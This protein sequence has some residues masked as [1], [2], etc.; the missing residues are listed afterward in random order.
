MSR[1]MDKLVKLQ[2]EKASVPPVA[3]APQVDQ[4]QHRAA[5]LKRRSEADPPS[6]PL[7]AKKPSVEEPIDAA[8]ISSAPPTSKTPEASA[9][10]P[11]ASIPQ[12]NIERGLVVLTPPSKALA[13]ASATIIIAT[14]PSPIPPVITEV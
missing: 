9:T 3:S 4:P 13:S 5:S 10:P 2:Q 14:P 7:A 1:Q 11:A 8:P 6:T 12:E